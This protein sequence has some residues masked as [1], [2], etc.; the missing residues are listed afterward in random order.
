MYPIKKYGVSNF[1]LISF[2]LYFL[3]SCDAILF[4]NLIDCVESRLFD[5]DQGW[6]FEKLYFM[7]VWPNGIRKR[8]W[9]W[10]L[11]IYFLKSKPIHSH[12]HW[13]KLSWQ[14]NFRNLCGV[15]PAQVVMN[16]GFYV[17]YLDESQLNINVIISKMITDNM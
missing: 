9:S 1:S 15:C 16:Y 8:F 11:Q 17:M 4:L 3:I 2:L 10:L 6:F 14:W 5:G 12:L 13:E 7:L